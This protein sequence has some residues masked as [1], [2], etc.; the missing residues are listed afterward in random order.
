MQCEFDKLL[1][2]GVLGTGSQP[3][4]IQAQGALRRHI[5]SPPQ[6]QAAK[7]K[8][9]RDGRLS[10][11]FSQHEK[12]RQN[13]VQLS[14]I[15]CIAC[16]VNFPDKTNIKMTDWYNHCAATNQNRMSGTEL[17]LRN[18]PMKRRHS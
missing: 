4:L 17:H 18:Q 11:A 3:P 8:T 10:V 16:A 1:C 5:V 12:D 6:R 15:S 14:R 2:N 7:L 13:M 9:Q